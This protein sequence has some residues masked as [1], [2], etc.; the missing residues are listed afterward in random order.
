MFDRFTELQIN[1]R[2]TSLVSWT[3]FSLNEDE[4]LLRESV[5]Q[6][7]LEDQGLKYLE[8]YQAL[9]SEADSFFFDNEAYRKIHSLEKTLIMVSKLMQQGLYTPYVDKRGLF[10]INTF[11]FFEILK[12]VIEQNLSTK[13]LELG[14]GD[15][16]LSAFLNEKYGTKIK[17][18]DDFAYGRKLEGINSVLAD[19]PSYE[20]VENLKLAEALEKYEP[21]LVISSWLVN[22]KYNMGDDCKIL[23]FPSVKKYLWIGDNTKRFSSSPE[24]WN[25]KD[26]HYEKIDLKFSEFTQLDNLNNPLTFIDI[27]NSNEILKY[28]IKLNSFRANMVLIT[29]V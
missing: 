27:N 23:D 5:F 4:L 8:D 16:S 29:K 25:R 7:E 13:I 2:A 12:S 24:L 11:E 14:A 6:F 17:A 21:E 1:S 26:C 28:L 3:D 19:R 9:I 15:G 20:L 10:T 18:V 22:P